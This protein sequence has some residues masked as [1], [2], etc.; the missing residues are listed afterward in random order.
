MIQSQPVHG[1]LGQ[2]VL[3]GLQ[4]GLVEVRVAHQRVENDGPAVEQVGCAAVV[5]SAGVSANAL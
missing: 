5:F 2:H 3:R 4:R 1:A